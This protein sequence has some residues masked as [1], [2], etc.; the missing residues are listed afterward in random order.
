MD[1]NVLCYDDNL[2]ILRRYPLARELSG[3]HEIFKSQPQAV[4]DQIFSLPGR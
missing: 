1:T 3:G 4:A 2:D